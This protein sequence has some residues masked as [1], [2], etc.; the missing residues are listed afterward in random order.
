MPTLL[1]SFRFAG[2]KTTTCIN[3]VYTSMTSATL[4]AKVVFLLQNDQTRVQL[5]LNSDIHISSVCLLLLV[6]HVGSA[7]LLLTFQEGLL[8]FILFVPSWFPCMCEINVVKA[9]FPF[10][11]YNLMLCVRY[12]YK[13]GNNILFVNLLNI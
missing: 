11:F 12:V 6:F 10:P 5:L 1:F 8:H 2:R 7:D 4:Y 13:L 3:N 9:L